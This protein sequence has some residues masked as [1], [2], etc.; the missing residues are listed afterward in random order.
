RCSPR[1]RLVNARPQT[2]LNFWIR[3]SAVERWNGIG[4]HCKGSERGCCG[5]GFCN[6]EVSCCISVGRKDERFMASALLME[7]TGRTASTVQQNCF[8]TTPR[9]SAASYGVLW[10]FWFGTRKLNPPQRY[11]RLAHFE[12]GS[13]LFPG[14]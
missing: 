13:K 8:A 6:L 3:F 9:F 2:L 10:G 1:N 4:G 5:L 12:Q 14:N 11:P 7:Y